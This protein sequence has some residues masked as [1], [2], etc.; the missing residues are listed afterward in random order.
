MLKK[1]KTV[2]MNNNITVTDVFSNTLL[3][4]SSLQRFLKANP[5]LPGVV[6]TNHAKK[7]INRL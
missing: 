2:G 7:Y 4:P 5:H 6:L 3:P 1:L